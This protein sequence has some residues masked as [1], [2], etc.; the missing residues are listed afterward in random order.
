MSSFQ[1]VTGHHIAEV[2]TVAEGIKARVAWDQIQPRSMFLESGTELHHGLV[3]VAQAEVNEHEVIRRGIADPAR[4]GHLFE[5]GLGIATTAAAGQAM[6]ERPD[7]GG[8]ISGNLGR[9]LDVPDGV[10]EAPQLFVRLAEVEVGRGERRL[11]V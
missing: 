7:E 8:G 6:S 11:R 9:A 1:S 2:A 3:V 10:F 5:H 4:F